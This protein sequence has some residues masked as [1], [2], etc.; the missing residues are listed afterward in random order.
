M[1]IQ[2]YFN[3]QKAL[4]LS[5]K[6]KLELYQRIL[7]KKNTKNL[8]KRRHVFFAK[9]FVYNFL[10]TVIVVWIFWYILSQNNIID[11]GSFLVKL[12]NPNEVEAGYIWQVLDFKWD[13]YIEH[14]W[15]L[16]QSKNISNWDTVILKNNTRLVFDIDKSSKAIIKWPAKLILEKFTKDNKYRITLLEWDFIQMESIDKKNIQNIELSVKW[17]NIIV[18]QEGTNK[19]MNFQLV[20]QWDKHIVKN[21]WWNLLISRIDWNDKSTKQI[22]NKEQILTIQK[23][24]IEVYE[25]LDQFALAIKEKNISQIFTFNLDETPNI[26]PKTT[27]AIEKQNTWSQE[28]LIPDTKTNEDEIINSI[29][30]VDENTP[31]N[32]EV[33]KSIKPIISKDQENTSSKQVPTEIQIQKLR[34]ILVWSFLLSNLEEIYTYQSLWDTDKLNQGLYKLESKTKQLCTTFWITYNWN[35]NISSIKA[36]LNKIISEISQKYYVPP[37]YIQNINVLVSWL[38]S[39]EKTWFWSQ[40]DAEI[41]NSQRNSLKGNPNLIFKNN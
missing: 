38:T 30:S 40:T 36:S 23:N 27:L 10:V 35:Q 21:N 12:H 11:Y 31:E 29:M 7:M 18:K 22:L 17:E 19:P 32:P 37:K 13:F 6:E 41:I 8:L 2:E 16:F 24:D 28:N 3:I 20:K 1:K 33:S 15:E 9:N 39:I 14:N 4:S 34:T 5:E 25:N 26:T